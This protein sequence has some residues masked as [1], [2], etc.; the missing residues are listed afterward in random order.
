MFAKA[1]LVAVL[2]L[3]AWAVVARASQGAGHATRYTVRPGDTLWSI[4]AAHYAGDPR[5]GV[6]KI[7]HENHLGAT[8]IRPGERLLLP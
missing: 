8:L 4:A 3:V 6:W 2:A 1:L 7:Q 5:D